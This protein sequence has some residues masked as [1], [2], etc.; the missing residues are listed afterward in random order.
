MNLSRFFLNAASR[1]VQRCLGDSQALHARI[2][3]LFTSEAARAGRCALKV[4]HRLEVSE[5][6]GV[7]RLRNARYR[8]DPAP[9]DPACDCPACTG[10]SRAY[11]HHLDKCNEM[12]GPRLNTLHNLHYYQRLMRRMRQAIGQG[13][14]DAWAADFVVGPEGASRAGSA[15]A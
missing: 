11:L 4:L 8:S 7:I 1:D 3:D 10:Y 12:L 9:L 2:M 15:E 5:R 13:R 14:F 6:E